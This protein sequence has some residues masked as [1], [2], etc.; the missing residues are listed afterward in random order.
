VAGRLGAQWEAGAN[1]MLLD[2]TLDK[3]S[4]NVGN[5]AAGARMDF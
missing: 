5:R 1:L 2:A 3:G 4:A